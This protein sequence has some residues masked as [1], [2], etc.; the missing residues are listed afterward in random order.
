MPPHVPPD[1][2]ISPGMLPRMPPPGILPPGLPLPPVGVRP[3]QSAW[4]EHKTPDGRM[5]YYNIQSMQSTWEKPKEL[6][7]PASQ[8]LHGMPPGKLYTVIL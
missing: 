7:E 8:P 3:P 5:Y 2:G 6:S 1:M 4:T